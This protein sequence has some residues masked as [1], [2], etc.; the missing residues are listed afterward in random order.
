MRHHVL[1][2]CLLGLSFAAFGV[3][4]A[5]RILDY[6]SDIS[7]AADGGMQVTD[8]IRVRAEGAQIRHGIYRDFPTDYRDRLGNR[9]HVDFTPL[10]L[11]RDGANEPFHTEAQVNGVRVTSATRTR[12]WH[13]ANTPTC[14]VTRQH[15]SSAS[16]TITTSCTGT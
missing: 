11:T 1:L 4:A 10:T 14:W 12:L 6:H 2:A 16:S 3:H 8:T 7:L 9:V 13:R 5:E 15:A